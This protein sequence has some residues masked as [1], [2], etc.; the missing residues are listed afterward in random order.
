MRFLGSDSSS[1]YSVLEV[2]WGLDSWSEVAGDES[3][4]LCWVFSDLPVEDSLF[5][6]YALTKSWH[7]T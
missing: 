1:E 4:S 3:M 7:Q 6:C 5:F 2:Y